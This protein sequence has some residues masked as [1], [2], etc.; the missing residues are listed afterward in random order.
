MG[1]SRFKSRKVDDWISCDKILVMFWVDLQMISVI[2]FDRVKFRTLNSFRETPFDATMNDS[3]SSISSDD[4]NVRDGAGFPDLKKMFKEKKKSSVRTSAQHLIRCKSKRVMTQLSI[5]MP[6][7]SSHVN[8]WVVDNPYKW[9]TNYIHLVFPA[10]LPL[11]MQIRCRTNYWTSFCPHD[12]CMSLF[13]KKD[14]RVVNSFSDF[15]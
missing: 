14:V 6:S 5:L 2:K 12:D 1:Y 15:D 9:S 7:P 3:S 8:Y 10:F 13:M 4:Q 11:F